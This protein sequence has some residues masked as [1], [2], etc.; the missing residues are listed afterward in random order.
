MPAALLLTVRFHDGRY[1]GAGPWPPAPARLFQALVAGAAEG[2]RLP[3]EAA[4]A[5]RWLETLPPPLIA[6]PPA[7]Q[8]KGHQTYVPNNDLD[9]VG[10]DLA[11]VAEIRTAK[12]IRPHLFDAS[13]P[14]VYAWMLPEDAPGATPEA[15]GAVVALARRLCQLGR[16]VDMAYADGEVR[17]VENEVTLEA[18]LQAE[19]GRLRRP[20]R[21]GGGLT[22][23]CPAPGSLDSLVARHSAATRKFRRDG[24]KG[25]AVVFARPPRPRFRPVAY[26]AAPECRLY[27]IRAVDGSMGRGGFAPAPQTAVVALTEALRD[28]AAARLESAAVA[29]TPRLVVGRDAGEADK[30]QRVRIISLPSIGARQSKDRGVRRVLVEI[31][32]D[33]PIDPDTIDWAFSGLVLPA[34]LGAGALAPAAPTAMPAHY[35]VGADTGF[36][37][38]TSVTPLALGRATRRRVDPSEKK[39]KPASERA[40][41][42]E[43]AAAALGAALRHAGVAARLVSVRVQREPFDSAGRR[44]EE[45]ADGRF[46]KHALWHAALVF[47]RPVVGPLTIGDGRYLGLGLFAPRKDARADAFSF[48]IRG[49]NV[50]AKDRRTFLRAV[51]RALMAR[52]CDL[53]GEVGREFSGHEA[54]GR[55]ARGGS[56][57]HVFLAA[58]GDPLSHLHVLAPSLCDRTTRSTAPERARFDAVVS[59]LSAVTLG[60]I[61]VARLAPADEP[62]LADAARSWVSATPY[63]PTR[64]PKR[65]DSVAALLEADLLLECRRRGLRTPRVQIDAMH[66][67]PRG[68][69]SCAA[70]LMFRSPVCGPILLGRGSHLGNGL[71]VPARHRS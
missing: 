43:S 33:C 47:D 32:P 36:R 54:D 23:D 27:D 24:G 10:G 1:H 16:G 15:A 34:R 48:S 2:A 5:L 19:G 39:A 28:A 3:D 59:G 26:G 12:Q 41:E 9:A 44:A 42:E 17:A 18:I 51:R 55:P 62:S 4:A 60:R 46:S 61:G 14:V 64:T 25:K 56:H 35:G 29:E 6:A 65:S 58:T 63:V 30:R 53:H 31:P 21:A 66:V 22:L 8:A 70:Q 20:A 69:V 57:D 67:G 68:G 52:D 71:F 38:W 45:F 50:A 37:A 13:T 11:R 7:R 40:A 49:V